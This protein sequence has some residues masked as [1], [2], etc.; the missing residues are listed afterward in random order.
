LAPGDTITC[1]ASFTIKQSDLDSGSVK[2]TAQGHGYFGTTPVNSN[3]DDET[4]TADQNP[5]LTLLKIASP[6]MYDAVDDVI[7]YSYIMTN[8]G[9]VTIVA[10]FSIDDDKAIDEACPA[11]PTSLAP[12]DSITCSASYTITQADMDAMQVKNTAQGHGYFDGDEIYSNYDDET[13]YRQA[14]ALLPTA[15]TCQMYAAGPSAWPAMYDSFTYQV[16]RDAISSVSPGVIFY[17][18]TIVAPSASFS[19]TVNE[20][21]TL[22]WYDMLVQTLGQAILYNSDC[23]KFTQAISDVDGT[24]TFDVTGASPGATYYIGIKYSPSNLVGQ[25]VDKL[26]GNYPDN[27]Y[28]WGTS[29]N[30]SPQ[31][32]SDV[33]IP[34]VWK[35]KL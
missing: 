1:T 21:N 19:I 2:N 24:V 15:T 30:S 12:G 6:T 9:N 3:Y 8:T 27:R 26:N 25:H 31:T 5:E 18:N 29:I 33:S 4:V 10:P 35:R 11:I 20:T 32:G 34:V 16:K 7:T 13:V 23:S 28:F 17:Y 14:A 22:G